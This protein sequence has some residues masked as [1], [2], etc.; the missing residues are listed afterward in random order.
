[1]ADNHLCLQPADPHPPPDHDAVEVAHQLSH[2]N[3]LQTAHHGTSVKRWAS[4]S[5]RSASEAQYDSMIARGCGAAWLAL[6]WMQAPRLSLCCAVWFPSRLRPRGPV[7]APRCPPRH[8]QSVR[9][10]HPTRFLEPPWYSLACS[11]PFSSEG[12][13]GAQRAQQ[14]PSDELEG[15]RVSQAPRPPPPGPPLE[16]PQG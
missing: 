7:S 12:Q 8:P 3:T 5:L 16:H 11:P 15:W 2:Q 9:P 14:R 4:P 1:M 6:A 10:G 13:L